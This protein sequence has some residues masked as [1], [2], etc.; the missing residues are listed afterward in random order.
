MKSDDWGKKELMKETGVHFFNW[1][2]CGCANQDWFGF[3]QASSRADIDDMIPNLRKQMEG[4]EDITLV[5]H[6]KGG[7]LILNYL[8]NMT[9]EQAE[10]QSI[11]NAVTIDALTAGIVLGGIT[12]SKPMEGASVTGS[13]VR[14]ISIYNYLDPANSYGWGYVGGAENIGVTRPGF[15]ET[16]LFHSYKGDMAKYIMNKLNVRYDHGGAGPLR[17]GKP[18][19]V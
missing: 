16:L 18:T 14:T 2:V 8:Q 3:G 17:I 10:R 4:M 7:N 1:N 6:S 5:G 19:S 12:R 9:S 11:K 13:G 15:G